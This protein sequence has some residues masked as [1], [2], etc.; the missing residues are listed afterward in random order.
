MSNLEA[1]AVLNL[2]PTAAS[3][4]Y[5]RAIVRLRSALLLLIDGPSEFR[6]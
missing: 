5:I 1:A 4:R 2:R 3:N 6:K